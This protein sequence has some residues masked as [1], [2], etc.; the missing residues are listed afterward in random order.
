MLD[1]IFH[2]D[3][4]ILLWIQESVR[5]PELTSVFKTITHLGDKGLLWIVLGLL[6]L[7]P[8]KTRRVGFMTLLSLGVTALI[9]NVWLK[10]AVGR[11]RPYEVISGLELLVGR[12]SDL[13]F[14]SGHAAS[15]FTASVILFKGLPKWIGIWPLILAV[16]IAFSRL[17]V[18]IHYPSDVLVGALIG[19]VVA[20]VIFAI[21]GKRKSR[22]A[23]RR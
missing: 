14:P 6:L 1:L 5:T 18:G 2:L 16:L 17:Y 3:E 20:Q 15:S 8:R 23:F 22:R 4:T 11:V 13:S 19:I 7:I 12:A 9:C 21:F 10:E